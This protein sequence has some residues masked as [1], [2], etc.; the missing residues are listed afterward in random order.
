[1]KGVKY[2]D[3]KLDYTLLPKSALDEVVKVLMYGAKKYPEANNWKKVSDA[4]HRYNKA[5]LRHTFSEVD[6]ET[7]DPES[8]LY[9]LAHAVCSNLFALHFAIEEEK[10]NTTSEDFKSVLVMIDDQDPKYVCEG[11]VITPNE[12]VVIGN[13]D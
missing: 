8:K 9:H 12:K 10:E 7:K 1:M 4:R 2:D 13:I 5:A 3:E 11:T 6:G